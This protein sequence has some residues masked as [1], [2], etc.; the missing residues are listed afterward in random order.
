MSFS[1]LQQS[2]RDLITAQQVV[3]QHA[4]E[5]GTLTDEQMMV[6]AR[7]GAEE[8]RL[9]DAHNTLIAGQLAHRS[10][11]ELGSA[12]LA[13]R[14]GYRTAQELVRVTTGSTARDAA[15][16]VRVGLL[17]ADTVAAVP[18]QPW[19]RSVGLAVTAGT[20][21]AAAADAIRTGLGVPTESV[22]PSAL[23]TAAEHLCVEATTL[24][25]DRIAILARQVRDEIDQAGIADRE[26]Q[27]HTARGLRLIKQA[28]GMTRLIWVM[29]PETA[30]C[31]TD[32]FDRATSP[33]RGGPRFVH[34]N[35]TS[36][37]TSTSGGAGRDGGA[38]GSAGGSAGGG[39][40]AGRGGGGG[41]GI[42]RDSSTDAATAERI[43]ADP[44]STDTATAERILADPRSTE[45]IAS[46]TFAELLRHGA[47]TDSTQ[48]LGSGAPVV[49]ILVTATALTTLIAPG[50]PS[51]HDSRTGHGFIEGQIDPVNITTVER[52]ACS[53]ATQTIK[54]NRDGTPLDVGREQRLYT[55]QQRTALA[56]RDGGCM[57]PG[58]NRPPSWCECHHIMF[59]ARDHG[60]TDLADGILLCRHHHLLLHNNGWEIRRDGTDY[61]LIPP[62]DIDRERKPIRMRS[63]N[64]ALTDPSTHK[65]DK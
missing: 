42:T 62:P 51:G 33:R 55:K 30:A 12:G 14:T 41:G 18:T 54:L 52:L 22:P 16:S 6:M 43:L 9:A 29:D 35:S 44:R 58:C 15:T 20:L 25:V 13:Q 38:G 50:A 26:H 24:D 57:F 45:Q 10:A 31:V 32:L 53:G 1:T 60:G 8:S 7:L 65:Q 48:L 56:I 64:R 11:P 23:T 61:W 21:T 40:S 2:H 59:W 4:Q 37:S 28:D 49:R 27:R 47:T 39:S 3:L 46:D 19:L 34:S 17:T 63:R 36:T 5:Y